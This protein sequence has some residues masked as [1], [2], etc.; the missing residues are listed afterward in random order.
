MASARSVCRSDHLSIKSRRGWD[1]TGLVPELTGLASPMASRSMAS[2][3]PSVTMACRASPPL[4][5][6]AARQARH[7]RDAGRLRRARV[8]WGRRRR[9]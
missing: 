2:W 3:S 5:P 1:M 7:R 8:G 6:D 9:V 4:R